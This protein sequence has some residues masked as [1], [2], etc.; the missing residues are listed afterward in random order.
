MIDITLLNFN[1]FALFCYFIVYSFMGWCLET[2]YTTIRKKEFVNRGFLHGPF[3]PIYG[4]AILS[5][6]VLLKPIENNYIFLLLGSIFLTS[7]I[8]YITGYILETTFDSTWWDYSDEPY[9]LHGRICLKFSIIWGFISILILKVIHPYIEYT[10][11]LIPLNP[12]VFLFYITLVYFILDFIITIITIIKL[13]SLLTQLITAYSELT[14][15][16]LDFKLNLGNTKSIPELRIKLDQLIDLAETKM[17]RKK[18]NIENI[19]KEVKIKYD[20]LFIKKYPDYSRLIK[21]FPDL[22]FKALDAILKDVKHI[23]H[24]DKKG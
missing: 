4:F 16:F 6:I 15:K 11:N 24:K 5:I 12:G 22:K 20:S 13:K 14:D 19:V 7:L 8:E 3:C 9:N 23:I 10:V 18:S 17:S 1:V 21:A 2:V